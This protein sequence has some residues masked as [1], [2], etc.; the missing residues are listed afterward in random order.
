MKKYQTFLVYFKVPY[1]NDVQKWPAL[2]DSTF[3]TFYNDKVAYLA[4][5]PFPE[6]Y[7]LWDELFSITKKLE[8]LF[9]KS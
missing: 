5:P 8:S 4:K 1:A 9:F 3:L 7:Q 6:R 2:E